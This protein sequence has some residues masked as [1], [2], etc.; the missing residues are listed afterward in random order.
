M[1][2]LYFR[3]HGEQG[4]VEQGRKRVRDVDRPMA[5]WE[6]QAPA[7]HVLPI[8]LPLLRRRIE[9]RADLL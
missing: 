4:N 3:L 1:P 7:P 5:E 6:R 8:A 2:S 9:F